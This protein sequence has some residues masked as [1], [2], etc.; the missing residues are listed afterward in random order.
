MICN[1]KKRKELIKKLGFDYNEHTQTYIHG[2]LGTKGIL[3]ER[4]F[5]FSSCSNKGI[6]YIVY[7]QGR[8]EGKNEL[9]Q[10]LKETLRLEEVR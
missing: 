2:L 1:D 10:T 8:I 9:R 4:L 5:D 3:N 7:M 6:I